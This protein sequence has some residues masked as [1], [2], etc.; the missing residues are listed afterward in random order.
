MGP[1]SS[2]K[3]AAVKE[4]AANYQTMVR[5]GCDARFRVDVISGYHFTCALTGYRLE[6]ARGFNL[7]QA[8][9]IQAHASRGPD[10]AT[11]GSP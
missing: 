11:N 8:A 9:H 4:N 2:R 7:L 3:I 5:R 10:I 1:P 6:T